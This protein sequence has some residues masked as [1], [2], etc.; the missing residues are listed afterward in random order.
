MNFDT[1]AQSYVQASSY[2]S[3]LEIFCGMTLPPPF[4]AF[5]QT[6]GIRLYKVGA[7]TLGITRA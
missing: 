2:E 6:R 7:L 5:H 1:K 3:A 4:R